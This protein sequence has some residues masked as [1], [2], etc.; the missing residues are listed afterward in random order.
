[1]KPEELIKIVFKEE[2]VDYELVKIKRKSN[3]LIQARQRSAY[4]LH[5]FFPFMIN[6]DIM[7]YFGYN[8][9]STVINSYK[10]VTNYIATEKK[11]EKEMARLIKLIRAKMERE[12][13][14]RTLPTGAIE[15]KMKDKRLTLKLDDNIYTLQVKKLTEE[16]KVAT[17]FLTFTPEAL[18]GITEMYKLLNK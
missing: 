15:F 17:Q 9:P 14:Y 1:M 3:V 5:Y 13:K 2:R 16:K 4:L 18:E 8:R 6:S 7:V 10:R 11:Y 12:N